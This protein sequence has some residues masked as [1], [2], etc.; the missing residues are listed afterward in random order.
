MRIEKDA[1]GSLELNDELYG[2]QTKRALDNFPVTDQIT[3]LNLIMNVVKIKKAACLCN[4]NDNAFSKEV[5]EAINKA[6]GDVLNRKYDSSFVTPAIQGGAGTSINMN[7]NEVISNLAL[8]NLGFKLG[9]YNI[10]NP[11]DTINKCQ[12]TNDVIPTAIKMTLIEYVKKLIVEVEK[13]KKTL[14]HKAIEFKDVIKM[15]RT[16]LQDAVPMMLGQEFNAYAT[17]LDRPLNNLNKII[18]ELHIVNLG[19]SACGTAINVTPYYLDNIINYLNNITEEKFI[20]ANDLFDCTSNVDIYS[21]LSGILKS[22][23][24][25]LSKMSNDLRLLSSGPITGFKEI[26]LPIRQNGSSIMPGKINPV[27]PEVM[28]QIAFN[29]IGNDTTITCAVEAGQ[30]ELN[31]FLPIIATKLFDSLLTLT[32]GIKTLNE[33]CCIGITTNVEHLKNN[34]EHSAGISTVLCP[35]IGYLKASEVAHEAVDKN[36]TVKE[37]VLEKHLLPEDKINKILNPSSLAFAHHLKE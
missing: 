11:N 17:M 33:N 20:Q 31:A 4:Y 8:L 15:A 25:S 10:I 12:S 5:C 22:L 37:V 6:C 26:N 23:A 30:L 3:D 19:A 35:Y 29:V 13:L 14:L 32:K 7:V 1:V 2:V 24:L 9:E 16:Q 36:E 18:N 21:S 27:I 28:N 34:V